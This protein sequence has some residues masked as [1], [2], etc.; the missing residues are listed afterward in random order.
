MKEKIESLAREIFAKMVVECKDCTASECARFALA[1]AEAFYDVLQESSNEKTFI[2]WVNTRPEPYSGHMAGG[3]VR[4]ESIER[5]EELLVAFDSNHD[6][7]ELW[8]V[9]NNEKVMITGD[10]EIF[11]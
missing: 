2:Y 1:E 7:G 6:R 3:I 9:P 5:A 11:G 8:E 10:C 4:A